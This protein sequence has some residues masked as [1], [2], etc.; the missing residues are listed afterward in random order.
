MISIK[1][2]KTSERPSKPFE[3]A[4]FRQKEGTIYA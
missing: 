1:P 4:F 3:R 2:S